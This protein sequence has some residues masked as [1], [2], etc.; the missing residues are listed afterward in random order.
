MTGTAKAV[1]A[2]IEA[3]SARQAAAASDAYRKLVAASAAGR[4]VSPEKAIEVLDAAGKTSSD[5]AE[6]VKAAAHR[7]ELQS[8]VDELPGHQ[9]R[10]TAIQV[11]LDQAWAEYS[12]TIE[13]WQTT[14][15]AVAIEKSTVEAAVER[16][17]RAARE[18]LLTCPDQDLVAEDRRLGEE[19]GRLQKR[20]VSIAEWILTAQGNVRK[21]EEARAS[22]TSADGK[23]EWQ[24]EVKQ[25]Q[26]RVAELERERDKVGK[27]LNDLRTQRAVLEQ[28]RRSA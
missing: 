6:D 17:S 9:E 18:L 10:L 4:N 28:R 12:K 15:D 7:L 19:I 20:T 25:R 3:I 23:A 13:K 2:G 1:V 14:R 5:F 26:E 27:Q 8:V 24:Q 11:K 16:S 21:A 22:S